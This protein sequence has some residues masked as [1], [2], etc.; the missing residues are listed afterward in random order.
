MHFDIEWLTENEPKQRTDVFYCEGYHH[1][2]VC[3][4]TGNERKVLISLEILNIFNG[5]FSLV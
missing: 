1:S 3:I 4:I 2:P 5:N